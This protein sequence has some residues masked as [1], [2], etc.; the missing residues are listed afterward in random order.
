M[1]SKRILVVD[2]SEIISRLVEC[3]IKGLGA[4]YQ[5]V[6]A[7][8]GITALAELYKQ[9]FDLMITDYNM[10]GMTGM[11]LAQK[12][13]QILPDMQIVLMTGQDIIETE[14]EARRRHLKFDSYLNKPITLA[15]LSRVLQPVKR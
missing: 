5:V 8:D 9:S 12:V 6:L 15:Q 14:A 4:G 11:E 13:R 2:D 3:N 10:P 7:Q 1:N